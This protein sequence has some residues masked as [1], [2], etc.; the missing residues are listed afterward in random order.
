MEEALLSDIAYVDSVENRHRKW[1]YA[2]LLSCKEYFQDWCI[3]RFITNSW[4][5]FYRPSPFREIFFPSFDFLCA[6]SRSEESIIISP[7]SVVISIAPPLFSSSAAPSEHFGEAPDRSAEIWN[8]NLS[9]EGSG[10]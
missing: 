3:L 6:S 4:G 1:S 7:F 9:F 5:F 10:F 8:P 2:T